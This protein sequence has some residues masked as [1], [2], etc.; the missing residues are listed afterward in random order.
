[1]DILKTPSKQPP[2]YS[3]D[4]NYTIGWDIDPAV[5]DFNSGEVLIPMAISEAY[6][7]ALR[8]GSYAGAVANVSL[9]SADAG[10]VNLA[11]TNIRSIRLTADGLDIYYCPNVNR[12][13]SSLGMFEYNLPEERLQEYFSGNTQTYPAGLAAGSV[14]NYSVF[15][16]LYNEGV[17]LSRRFNAA[18]RV[19]VRKLLDGFCSE[20]RDL[21][22][23]TSIELVVELDNVTDFVEGVEPQPGFGFTAG[24]NKFAGVTNTIQNA[25]IAGSWPGGNA[26]FTTT[27]TYTGTDVFPYGIGEQVT[28]TGA[29]AKTITA[30]ALTGVSP[31]TVAVSVSGGNVGAG[32]DSIAA[33]AGTWKQF[34]LTGTTTATVLAQLPLLTQVAIFDTD[35]NLTIK[36]IYLAAAVQGTGGSS[37][38]VLVTLSAASGV[39][40]ASGA[41]GY[42]LP[43]PLFLSYNGT[44]GNGVQIPDD[45]PTVDDYDNSI[46]NMWVG[47]PVVVSAQ[48]NCTQRSAIISAIGYSGGKATL[49]FS[50]PVLADGAGAIAALCVTPQTAQTLTISYPEVWSHVSYRLKQPKGIQ[51]SKGYKRWVYDADSVQALPTGNFYEKTF[52]L[53]PGCDFVVIALCNTGEVSSDVGDLLSY[54]LRLDGIDLTSRDILLSGS[55]TYRFERLLNG[56]QY[57][58]DDLDAISNIQDVNPMVMYQGSYV[59][60]QDLLVDGQSH[61]LT[62]SLRNGQTSTY[63][64]KTLNLFKRVI[65]SL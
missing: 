11:S 49:T 5:Y 20:L 29:G 37:A 18:L 59:I 52:V 45:S 19:P 47:Q 62:L 50:P 42:M 63:T 58:N 56:Y 36:G 23:Y 64:A 16:E 41:G 4:S 1:M 7:A 57:L 21:R 12:L 22:S 48:A 10:K 32:N 15:R 13:I 35:S 34:M 6:V 28:F 31:S 24:V 27:A 38:N 26:V 46:F 25:L 54:R 33:G 61:R 2:P 53:E 8:N 55:Q 43:Q 3:P 51:M 30:I 14:L 40:L 65:S 60:L 17:L 39:Q 9:G 44:P